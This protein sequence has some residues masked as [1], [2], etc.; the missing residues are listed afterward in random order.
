[1]PLAASDNSST[2][3]SEFT[4][5]SELR[6]RLLIEQRRLRD[7]IAAARTFENDEQ[8]F[9]REATEQKARLRTIGIFE[10]STRG[11]ACPLCLQPLTESAE[12]PS[13]SQVH[14]ALTTV[15][16]RLDSV[17]RTAPQM[18]RAVAELE[19]N[20]VSVQRNLAQN[21]SEMEA[22][23]AINEGLAQAQDETTKRA[24]VLARGTTR[25]PTNSMRCFGGRP[26]RRSRARE[27]RF[28]RLTAQ[29]KNDRVGKEASA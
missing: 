10:G 18:E 16:V 17:T 24:H 6:D 1:M 11:E 9:S 22:V 5:L 8:G 28:H 29:W 12:L 14:A 15:S 27:T 7:Q 25:E 20:L 23:R 19:Q 26:E 21:R 3:I 13:V 2:S 4:R